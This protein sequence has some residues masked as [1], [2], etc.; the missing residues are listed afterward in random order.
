[1]TDST[2]S[3]DLT[4][5][6]GDLTPPAPSENVR[7]LRAAKPADKRGW[8]WGTGRRKTAV[9][10]VRLKPA[11]GSDVGVTIET[12]VKKVTKTIDQYFSE[13][14]D[15]VDAV[16]ALKLVGVFDKMRVVAK[17]QGGGL[18]GQSQALRLAIARALRDYDPTTEAALRDAGFLTRDARE[19]ER[20][21]YGQA[22]ARRRFQ[23]S[24]R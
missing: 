18:M 6:L 3:S 20:K 21:K 14:R 13:E 12:Q 2:L 11:S 9:A 5:G 17:L 19:V 23:F 22:G 24:K 8:W 16:S 1:M 7:P 15:R 4:L 10:R